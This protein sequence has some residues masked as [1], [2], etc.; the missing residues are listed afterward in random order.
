MSENLIYGGEKQGIDRG[1]EVVFKEW[2][3]LTCRV[4]ISLDEICRKSVITIGISTPEGRG[5]S[6]PE[7]ERNGRCDPQNRCEENQNDYDSLIVRTG[8]THYELSCLH[9]FDNDDCT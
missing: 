2:S 6:A 8:T 9:E 4:T 5:I 1:A 3:I 7:G